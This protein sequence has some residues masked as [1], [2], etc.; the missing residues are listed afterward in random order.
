MAK[1]TR[2]VVFQ[3]ER[4]SERKFEGFFARLVHMERPLSG[5]L[6]RFRAYR[7][8]GYCF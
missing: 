1:R 8:D 5:T 6:Y 7:D 4:L 2:R 3:M